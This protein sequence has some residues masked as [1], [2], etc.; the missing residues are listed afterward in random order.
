MLCAALSNFLPNRSDKIVFAPC[1]CMKNKYSK[2]II[3][4]KFNKVRMRVAARMCT[5][6]YVIFR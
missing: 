6:S 3:M 2:F 5:F 4:Y 1:V